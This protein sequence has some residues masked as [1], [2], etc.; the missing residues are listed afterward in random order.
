MRY[1][2]RRLITL[3]VLA[4]A[5]ISSSCTKKSSEPSADALAQQNKAEFERLTQEGLSA[6][7]QGDLPTAEAKFQAALK[8]DESSAV[9]WNNVCSIHNARQQWLLG[10]ATCRK[11]TELNPQF[12]MANNN[13]VYAREQY[14]KFEEAAMKR[15]N[16]LK[17][18]KADDTTRLNIGL[19]FY[20][21][22]AYEKSAQLWSQ[23]PA[24]STEYARAQNNVAT[25]YIQLKRFADA[26][27]ALQNALK[28]APQDATFLANKKW[29]DEAR[30]AKP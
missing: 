8:L 1:S 27:T 2:I 16:A 11:A 24:S 5:L 25:S 4:I 26:E 19:E 23:I 9:A 28:L 21:L 22:G 13:L 10:E 6:F 3:P 14:T 20:K 30:G 18:S 7:Q 12:E 17:K 29:L 15:F